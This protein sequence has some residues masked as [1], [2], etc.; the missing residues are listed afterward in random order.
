MSAAV[1]SL[2]SEICPFPSRQRNG[3]LAG[4]NFVRVSKIV[5]LMTGKTCATCSFDLR[6]AGKSEGT[7]SILDRQ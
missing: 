2:R 6:G 7:F 3:R 4:L 1:A 5:G